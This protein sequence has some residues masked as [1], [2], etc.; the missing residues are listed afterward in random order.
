MA[1]GQDHN[2][3]AQCHSVIQVFDILVEQTNAAGRNKL[4]DGRG[5]IRAM[6]AIER[7]AKVERPCAKW[8]ARTACHESRQVGLAVNHF[9]RRMPI[10][11]FDHASN[12]LRTG[13]CETF[14]ADANTIPQSAAR[15]E[16]QV[17]VCMGRI[18]NDGAGRFG[19][20]IIYKLTLELRRERL[21]VP[22]RLIFWRAGRSA[23]SRI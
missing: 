7:I 17:K 18:D 20:L 4:T 12:A 1:A 13:P 19:R 21:C 3:S 5:L 22:L 9:W 11:P 6:N 23:A 16:N 15:T 2:A 10:R 8:I 14:A